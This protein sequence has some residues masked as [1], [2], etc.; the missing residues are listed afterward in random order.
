MH[1]GNT[2]NGILQGIL[3]VELDYCY[4][5]TRTEKTYDEL[6]TRATVRHTTNS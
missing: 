5:S 2:V 4:N 3:V 1:G 6:R